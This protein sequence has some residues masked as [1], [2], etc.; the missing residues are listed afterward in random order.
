M[1]LKEK[2]STD[3]VCLGCELQTPK[4]EHDCKIKLTSFWLANWYTRGASRHL[5]DDQEKIENLM[6]DFMKNRCF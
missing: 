1:E 5:S 2:D 4:H 3:Y 6:A